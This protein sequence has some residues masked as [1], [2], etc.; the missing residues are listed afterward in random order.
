MK[1]NIFSFPLAFCLALGSIIF[2]ANSSYAVRLSVDTIWTGTDLLLGRRF[3][4]KGIDN[5]NINIIDTQSSSFPNAQIFNNN[6]SEASLLFTGN[7]VPPGEPTDFQWEIEDYPDGTFGY[8]VESTVVLSTPN[9]VEEVGS[10][11]FTVASTTSSQSL[12][13]FS[14]VLLQ[15]VFE[16][17]ERNIFYQ[18][19]GDTFTLSPLPSAGTITGNLSILPLSNYI[20]SEEVRQLEFPPT[21]SFIVSPE[22]TVTII[23]EPEP[24]AAVPEPSTVIGLLSVTSLGTLFKRKRRV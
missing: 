21:Q 22:E 16:G 6:T 14:A 4:F 5:R 1:K 19:P 8:D 11:G 3:I 2:S 17:V 13:P 15:T 18:V 24:M 23:V 9:G 20:S 7:S 10:G 12:S